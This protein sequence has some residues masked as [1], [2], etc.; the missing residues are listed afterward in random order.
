MPD[1]VLEDQAGDGGEPTPPFASGGWGRGRRPR[2]APEGAAEGTPCARR[3]GVPQLP[4]PRRPSP[5]SPYLGGRPRCTRAHRSR[6][7]GFRPSPSR[8]NIRSSL[9]PSPSYSHE[10]PPGLGLGAGRRGS[11]VRGGGRERGPRASSPP[12]PPPPPPLLFF[13]SSFLLLGVLL[14]L[15]ARSV[16]PP[17][18]PCSRPHA[19]TGP[20][21]PTMRLA[22]RAPLPRRSPATRAARPRCKQGPAGEAPSG[23]P[24]APARPAPPAHAPPPRPPCPAA[25][26]MAARLRSLARSRPARRRVKS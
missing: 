25:A 24:R 5:P 10:L 20:P 11:G 12:P 22:R 4:P 1:P 2:R 9:L 3:P 17:P 6:P 16:W 21:P 14:L 19:P 15:L 7:A 18:P 26:A 13:A 8:P 23:T